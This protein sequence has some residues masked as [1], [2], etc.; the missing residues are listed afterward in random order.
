MKM[1]ILCF[2]VYIFYRKYDYQ[3]HTFIYNLLEIRRHQF[4][5]NYTLRL[6]NCLKPFQEV[7]QSSVFIYHSI[8]Y[9][10]YVVHVK[11]IELS[12]LLGFFYHP[13]YLFI[14]TIHLF[15]P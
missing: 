1:S 14:E 4:I 8:E 11:Q 7:G 5:Y 3:N 13:H 12:Q 2:K 6:L 9:L 15:S 10:I